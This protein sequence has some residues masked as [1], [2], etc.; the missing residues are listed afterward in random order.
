MLDASEVST[1]LARVSDFNAIIAREAARIN[2]PVVDVNSK[3]AE[4]A[5]NPPEFFGYAL[6]PQL[7]RGMFSLDG[8][9]PSNISHALI[10]N[11]F[12]KAMNQAFAMNIAEISPQVLNIMFLLD[13]FVDKDNDG[14]ITGRPGL[15]LIET[16]AFFMGLTGDS[17]DLSPN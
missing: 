13:P 6:G 8:T 4:W 16:L 14:K 5:I 10:A 2:M 7:Q 15:G 9:H 12:I 11:E 1:V 17:N 3:F